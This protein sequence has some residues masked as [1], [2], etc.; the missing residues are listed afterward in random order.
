MKINNPIDINF[1]DFFLD[2]RFDCIKT[3]QNK[4]WI[5][6]HFPK[7]D[8]ESDMGNNLSIWRY[9]CIEFHFDG[10]KLYL[11]WCDYLSYIKSGKSHKFDMWILEDLSICSL[12]YVL[13]T[14]NLEKSNYSVKFDKN[15][16]NSII[17]IKKSRVNLWFECI[18]EEVKTNN[19]NDYK[20]I[21]FGLSDEGYDSFEKN[22][23]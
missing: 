4:E 1:K 15:L 9:G 17:R 7:P 20:L 23:D 5:L 13:S 14:L 6:N 11:I 16:N 18:D 21:A 10:D 22:F 2:G 12:S 3:G 8:D 19:P